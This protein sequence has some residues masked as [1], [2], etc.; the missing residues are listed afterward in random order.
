MFIVDPEG[1]RVP[2]AVADEDTLWTMRMR[3]LQC[4]VFMFDD[5]GIVDRPDA[6]GQRSGGHGRQAQ[7][8]K[9]LGHSPTCAQPSGQRIEDQPTSMG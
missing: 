4:R 3:N 9:R 6:N 1:M 8:R 7:N 2:D 5:L